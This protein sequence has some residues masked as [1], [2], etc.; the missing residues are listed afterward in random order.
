MNHRYP[1]P[2]LALTLA[3]GVL[4]ASPAGASGRPEGSIQKSWDYPPGIQTL[5][6]ESDAQ[7]ILIRAGGPRLTGRLIGDHGDSVRLVRTGDRLEI[8][9]QAQRGWL[10]WGRPSGR[11]E[12]SVPE[13][14]DLDLSS[15][16]GAIVVQAAVGNLRARSASGD[17]EAAQ[18]G[19]SADV[20][21]ASGTVRLQGFHGAVKAGSL[22]GDV[23]LENVE[24]PI[25]ATTMSGDVNGRNLLPDHSSRFTAVSGDVLLSLSQGLEDYRIDA[26]TVSGSINVGN[27]HADGSLKVGSGTRTLVVRSVSGDVDVR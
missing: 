8:T 25:Q 22:S 18:G 5:V 12:L 14:L 16:S 9:V 7:D 4:F 11:L 6:V 26:E 10:A 17:I 2:A 3:F 1:A 27:S 15:A 13:G 24:G 21:S 20:D 23:L 19:R